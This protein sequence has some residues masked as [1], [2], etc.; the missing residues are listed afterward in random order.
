ML[1][2]YKH[3]LFKELSKLHNSNNSNQINP[4][5]LYKDFLDKNNI[6]NFSYEE[7]KEKFITELVNKEYIL[8][9]ENKLIKSKTNN[10]STNVKKATK[11][12]K[13][14]TNNSN[15]NF[16]SN[17]NSESL[18]SI[19]ITPNF[20]DSSKHNYFLNL[21]YNYNYLE[22]LY[23]DKF[24]NMVRNVYKAIVEI[25]NINAINND[26]SN[27][28]TNS[29][30][31]NNKSKIN[32]LDQINSTSYTEINSFM[33]RCGIDL[34]NIK[35]TS[36]YCKQLLKTNRII[37]EVKLT[38]NNEKKLSIN[39]SN[40]NINR[41][42]II[43]NNSNIGNKNKEDSEDEDNSNDSSYSDKEN[44]INDNRSSE[45]HISANNDNSRSFL[46]IRNYKVPYPFIID[47]YDINNNIFFHLIVHD[48]GLN[49]KELSYL[50]DMK[51]REKS[52]GRIVGDL[53]KKMFIK[54]ISKRT[55]KI[56]EYLYV[57]NDSINKKNS[58]NINSKD[59]DI[60]IDDFVFQYANEYKKLLVESNNA[61]LNNVPKNEYDN[62][63]DSKDIDSSL[64]NTSN[65]RN[66]INNNNNIGYDDIN[67]S[68]YFLNKKKNMNFNDH[69][70]TSISN[71]NINN[72]QNTTKSITKSNTT[73]YTN[74]STILINNLISKSP[75]Y[76]NN[77]EILNINTEYFTITLRDIVKDKDK[78]KQLFK[79]HEL[80]QKIVE[81]K[82]VALELQNEF[83]NTSRNGNS[84]K[85][86]NINNSFNN[87]HNTKV[88]CLYNFLNNISNND[89]RKLFLDYVY[90]K[91][92]QNNSTSNS[93]SQGLKSFSDISFNRLIYILNEIYFHKVL[94]INDIKHLI[95]NILEKDKS[96]KIDRKTISNLLL[97]LEALGLVKL[98]KYEITMS[99]LNYK[100]INKDEVVQNK[101]LVMKLDV[102][103]TD[104]VYQDALKI[105]TLS[106]NKKTSDV[107]V[108]GNYSNNDTNSCYG[109]NAVTRANYQKDQDFNSI[110]ES[111]EGNINMTNEDLYNYNAEEDDEN[112]NNNIDDDVYADNNIDIIVGNI[113]N[114]KDKKKR[115][116]SETNNTN[117]ANTKVIN[118]SKIKYK[119]KSNR[120]LVKLEIELNENSGFNNDNNNVKYNYFNYVNSNTTNT[121]SQKDLI[122][123][124]LVSI[125]SKKLE[126][127][128][129]LLIKTSRVNIRKAFSKLKNYYDII[130]KMSYYFIN[131]EDDYFNNFLNYWNPA[132]K[133]FN[134]EENSSGNKGKNS[135]D[136]LIMDLFFD[137]RDDAIII[138]QYI[139][140]Y[141]QGFYDN[142]DSNINS[143]EKTTYINTIEHKT[144][145]V[146]NFNNIE[147]FE[148]NLLNEYKE[149]QT[150][151]EEIKNC[152]IIDY[153]EFTQCSNRNN[154]NQDINIEELINTTNTN[155]LL[156]TKTI[157]HCNSK[158]NTPIIRESF[159]SKSLV[160]DLD[161]L[162]TFF[163]NKKRKKKQV[164]ESTIN[165]NNNNK[166][167]DIYFTKEC[168]NSETR[169]LFSRLKHNVEFAFKNKSINSN[170]YFNDSNKEVIRRLV[171]LG[172][173]RIKK[174]KEDFSFSLDN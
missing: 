141:C 163:L 7:F 42:D 168:L 164:Q 58:N 154:S 19:V 133:Y 63:V 11:K 52:V 138:P 64:N 111:N 134:K 122:I 123:Y 142:S 78:N 22:N 2:I 85:N 94:S 82:E 139:N 35:N 140:K 137:N 13:V 153:E 56:F 129:N 43:N 45:N 70:N 57:I 108:Y 114:S 79:N 55:G 169:L 147:Q 49:V 112:S 162:T 76:Y 119:E 120:D 53:L 61:Y 25:C 77:N 91:L 87:E 117:I 103:E 81:D 90:I 171:L 124:N 145:D 166:T 167:F 118:R 99:N 59:E 71:I 67:K 116:K 3:R 31:K 135:N 143:N 10:S 96:Y 65:Y 74:I 39:N 132:L 106:V 144:Y 125:M 98:S 131:D 32:T 104:D 27:T 113:D 158:I 86:N 128:D 17:E 1:T 156:N 83:T 159:I 54:K 33:L 146:L 62:K 69:D 9:K 24:N 14:I 12:Q 18:V 37:S 60:I 51:G 26:T 107:L 46:Y 172:I 73:S 127:K 157:N 170:I 80:L 152:F 109:Y 28:N 92:S 150:I 160:S 161:V 101:M 89:K 93:G 173:L 36:H 130:R 72:N 75:Y 6:K 8:I 121:I 40:I 15:G 44:E 126:I 66:D 95:Y 23:K 4:N 5:D 151:E 20:L 16:N 30:N 136:K 38:N 29:A 48:D 68:N 149:E 115:Y 88:S 165:Y 97:K 21:L 148:N 102:E 105:I 41:L 100:Y 47:K 155:N 174:Y 34:K 110:N 50:C 84:N